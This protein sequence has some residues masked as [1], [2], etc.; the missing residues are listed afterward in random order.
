MQIIYTCMLM[1]LACLFAT[2]SFEKM[3]SWSKHVDTMVAYRLLPAG[4]VPPVLT[5]LCLAELVLALHLM[6]WGMTLAMLMLGAALLVLYSTAVTWN[7]LRGRREISCGCGGVL[8]SER[9]HIGIP[10]RNGLLL[11]GLYLAYTHQSQGLLNTDDLL[12]HICALLIACCGL[13]FVAI[14]QQVQHMRHK[15]LHLLPEKERP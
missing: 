3:R 1:A 4:A 14:G 15:W 2:T 5:L 11:L 10:I 8:E 12:L 9:L 6:L 13:L 7:L